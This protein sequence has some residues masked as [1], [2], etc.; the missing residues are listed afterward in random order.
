MR[1]VAPQERGCRHKYYGRTANAAKV[2]MSTLA[3]VG[4]HCC[5][6]AQRTQMTKTYERT[7]VVTSVSTYWAIL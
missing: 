1:Q 7:V 3:W 5:H 4:M 6:V 2:R